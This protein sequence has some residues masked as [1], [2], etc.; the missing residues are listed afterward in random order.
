[1]EEAI[2]IIKDFTE[3]LKYQR[4]VF[5]SEALAKLPQL[6]QDLA[7][8][9]DNEAEPVA[10]A[11]M[12]WCEQYAAVKAALRTVQRYEVGDEDIPPSDPKYE[13]TIRTNITLLK[14]TIQTAQQPPSPPTNSDTTQ[15]T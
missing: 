10:E 12:S 9:P 14:E 5:P 13:T 1:M 3:L 11:V 8:L 6:E 4:S 7:G 15:Q 2:S